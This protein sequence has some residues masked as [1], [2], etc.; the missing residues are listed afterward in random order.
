MQDQI[1]RMLE[2]GRLSACYLPL[3][4][5]DL[6]VM[7]DAGPL[8]VHQLGRGPPQP[9]PAPPPPP[10]FSAPPPPPTLARSSPQVEKDFPNEP[11]Q[12]QT[13]RQ[14]AEDGTPF[15]AVCEAMKAARAAAGGT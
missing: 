7:Y 1:A 12:A 3:F 13:L 8:R 11:D 2:T 15:C 9:A 6:H 4:R 5:D 14:A 10:S